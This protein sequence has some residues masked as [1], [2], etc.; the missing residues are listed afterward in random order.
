MKICLICGKEYEPKANF[1]QSKYCSAECRAVVR[2]ESVKI[3]NA[4][5]SEKLKN[6]DHTKKC[7]LCGEKFESWHNE[8]YCSGNCKKIA[9]RK[10]QHGMSVSTAVR[11]KKKPKEIKTL[12]DLMEIFKA[13]GKTPYDYHEWKVQQALKHV[14]KI[15]V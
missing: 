6:R 9:Q 4:K 12:D 13:E 3:Q 11:R 10:H 5:V 14:E 8:K 7:P 1:N 2:A 15:K